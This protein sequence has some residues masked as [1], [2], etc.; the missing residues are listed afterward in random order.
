MIFSEPKTK[1]TTRK[2]NQ[3]AL[4]ARANA[5][6]Q[7]SNFQCI[8][9]VKKDVSLKPKCLRNGHSFKNITL[10]N[11]LAPLA[12]KRSCHKEYASEIWKLSSQTI[13]KSCSTLKIFEKCDLDKTLILTGDLAVGVAERSYLRNIHVKYESCITFYSKGMA[14]DK[15]FSWKKW[16]RYM[17]FTDGLDLGTTE[18]YY[19]KE[20]TCEIWKLY[21]FQFKH[22]GQC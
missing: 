1:S 16:P 15:V 10:V 2:K 4:H 3:R 12:K 13:L 7:V 6:M 11:D 20:S 8:F 19:N 21:H 14:N 5:Q 18:R 17:T 9:K 22:H